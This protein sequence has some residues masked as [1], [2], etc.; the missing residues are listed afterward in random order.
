MLLVVLVA[1]VSIATVV[2]V[3]RS[4]SIRDHQGSQRGESVILSHRAGYPPAITNSIGMQLAW[5]P[6]GE[7]V[8][9]STT[10]KEFIDA[11]ER[12]HWVRISRPFYLGMHEVTVEQFRQFIEATGYKTDG[13]RG[14][15]QSLG[16]SGSELQFDLGPYTWRNPGFPQSDNHPVVLVSW[17]DANEFCR[18][19]S[20]QEKKTYRLPTEAEWEWACRAGTTT[21]FSCG[22][23][24][25]TLPE[26][27][28][29]HTV[30]PKA[31]GSS[32]CWG[33]GFLFT[34]PV[35][36]FRPN[37]FRLYD[38]HGNVQE[39][40]ADWYER[41]YYAESPKTD[42]T[43]PSTGTQRAVRGGSYHVMPWHARAAN[44]SGGT[45][46]YRYHDLGFRVV[47]DGP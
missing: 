33:E 24:E 12:A 45:P 44:R 29:I 28:N 10:T 31:D 35:G 43:G 26:V 8:M 13:E 25:S 9:G 34:L 20:R 23:E 7:F 18:W 39:W 2:V 16:F 37:P 32:I 6:A 46:S 38:M 22:N 27:A 19:L 1:V 3:R 17:N 36:T 11:D 5:V 30:Q 15:A 42:P 40:C 41:E 47:C 4:L 14:S 21:R